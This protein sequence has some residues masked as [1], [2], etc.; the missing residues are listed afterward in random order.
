MFGLNI[1]QNVKLAHGASET[2]KLGNPTVLKLQDDGTTGLTQQAANT[3]HYDIL[4]FSD[5]NLYKAQMTN[6]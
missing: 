3:Q 6:I 5:E 2:A 1:F 4:T